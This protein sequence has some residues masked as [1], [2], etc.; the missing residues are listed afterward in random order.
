[1]PGRRLPWVNAVSSGWF[2]TFGLRVLAGR[3]FETNDRLGRP[4][5]AIVNEAFA[6]RFFDGQNPLG[7]VARIGGPS[8][9]SDY[10]VVGIVSDSVYRNVREGTQPI[11][12]VAYAQLERTDPG[13]HMAVELAPGAS[14]DV[15]RRLGQAL[16]AVDAGVAFEFRPFADRVRGTVSRERL[17]ALLSGFFGILALLLAAVGLYGLT[18]Y[19]VSRRRTEI[20]VRMALGAEP[21]QVVRLVL[22]RTAW[23]VGLGVAMGTAVSVWAAKFVGPAL[24]FGLQPRDPAT[25]LWAAAVLVAVGLLTAWLPARRASRI[26]PTQVLREG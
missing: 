13:V 22:T 16:S 4:L 20:G 17:V 10:E 1:V 11:I 6:R 21:G 24:L 19:G 18:S 14:G 12:Y 15:Q 9:T 3:G 25:L 5:V 23:L 8:T 2:D 26:D 7:R